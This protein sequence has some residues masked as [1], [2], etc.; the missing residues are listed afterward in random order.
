MFVENNLLTLDQLFLSLH[1]YCCVRFYCKLQQYEL[2][3][4]SEN[5]VWCH[6]HY[7]TQSKPKYLKIQ[8]KNESL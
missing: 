6:S 2:R 8:T 1:P 3:T 5:N 4:I 7:E